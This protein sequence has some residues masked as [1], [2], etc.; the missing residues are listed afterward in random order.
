M[1]C[2][3]SDFQLKTLQ[4]VP[5]QL[6]T[7]LDAHPPQ[8]LHADP[9]LLMLKV[10]GVKAAGLILIQQ[11]NGMFQT[12][13]LRD[14]LTSQRFEFSSFYPEMLYHLLNDFIITTYKANKGVFSCM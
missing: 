8:S 10:F 14:Y 1:S 13:D 11:N 4:N 3:S 7:L 2:N 5:Q 6:L 12:Q 9:M